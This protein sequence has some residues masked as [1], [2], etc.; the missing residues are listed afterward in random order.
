MEGFVRE[1]F[2]L[3]YLKSTGPENTALSEASFP[4]DPQSNEKE[5]SPPLVSQALSSQVY[6]D[7]AKVDLRHPEAKI[8]ILA[9][10]FLE[11]VESWD[12][13][14]LVQD[15][16]IDSDP[17]VRAQAAL[18]LVKLGSHDAASLIKKR[19]ED[20]SPKV[21]LTALRGI[22]RLGEGLDL[23]TLGQ[24]L[25]DESPWVRRK[26]A[27]LL[28]WDRREEVLPILEKLSRDPVAKVRKAAL[29]SL[30][31]LLPE[32]SEDRLMKATADGDPELRKW[33]RKALERIAERPALPRGR[34][35]VSPQKP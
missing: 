15:A 27:T 32:E 28:G 10:Q 18:S 4:Q 9:I 33:A 25:S 3:I 31:A 29:Y 21:K 11:R 24:L 30:S 1:R 20:S 12:A 5:S 16:L 13:R 6:I 7:Q 17:E 34:I 35:T 26:M 2:R 8:R 19:L 14:S 23:D 22:F